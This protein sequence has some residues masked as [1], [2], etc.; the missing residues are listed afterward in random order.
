MCVDNNDYKAT[1]SQNETHNIH[2]C[3]FENNNPVRFVKSK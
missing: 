3:L 1:M 2:I